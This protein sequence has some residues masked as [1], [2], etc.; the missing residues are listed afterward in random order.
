MIK[1]LFERRRESWGGW[2]ASQNT[3][4]RIYNVIKCCMINDNILYLTN[5]TPNAIA[6]T[7]PIWSINE[8]QCVPCSVPVVA[9]WLSF[10]TNYT[11]YT[12]EIVYALSPYFRYI[13][14]YHRINHAKTYIVLYTILCM[15]AALSCM[16][17]LTQSVFSS[18]FFYG[19]TIKSSFI[20]FMLHSLVSLWA[21]RFIR[22]SIRI[23]IW[24]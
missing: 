17:S 4:Q 15:I 5:D 14:N 16:L 6:H 3:W 18:C 19:V 13:S 20:T 10:V 1:Y 9:V 2:R 7:T 23:I 12:V 8:S 24:I 22:T 21:N 11:N